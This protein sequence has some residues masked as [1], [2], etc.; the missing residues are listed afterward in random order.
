MP[1]NA[2]WCTICMPY[3]SLYF[4]QLSICANHPIILPFKPSGVSKIGTIISSFNNGSEKS[5]GAT[6]FMWTR[7]RF[8]NRISSFLFL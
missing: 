6:G 8:E 2:I 5:N 1:C 4:L 7:N 3:N